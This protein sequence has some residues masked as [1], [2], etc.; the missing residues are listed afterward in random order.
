MQTS[1]LTSLFQVPGPFVSM[2]TDVSPNVSDPGGQLRSRWTTMGHELA[3]HGVKEA[4]VE[5]VRDRLDELPQLPGAARRTLVIGADGILFDRTI[6]TATEWPEA[7]T[8]G[9]LPDL[10]GWLAQSDDAIP[11]V[12]AQVDRA[13]GDV[14][15]YVGRGRAPA[16]EAEVE[17]EQ[18]EL[19]KLPI[20]GWAQDKYQNR[21]ENN[22]RANAELVAEEVEHLRR[23]HRPRLIV[24]AGDVRARTELVTAIGAPS[25]A[26]DLVVVEVES[27]GRAAGVSDETLWGDVHEALADVVA[28]SQQELVGLLEEGMAGARQ[29]AFGLE[30]VAEA[31]AKAEVDTLVLDLPAARGQALDA[32]RLPGFPLPPGL[33]EAGAIAADQVLL[34]AATLTGSDVRLLPSGLAP[35]G[36]GVAA[37]LRW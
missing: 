19:T 8:A 31:F 17:G 13:G 1:D 30:P 36:D 26:E 9:P 3:R 35:R 23:Q 33:E 12:L 37:T 21:A 22:W 10:A 15:A 20:G 4:L 32:S 28:R 2:H 18:W 16:E 34:A 11:F 25:E 27:G 24:V 5:E 6:G 7:V 14:A 29:T